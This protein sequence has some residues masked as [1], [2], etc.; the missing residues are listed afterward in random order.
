MLEGRSVVALVPMRHHSERVPGKNFRPLAGKPL[1]AYILETLSACKSLDGIVVDT[2][3]ETIHQGVR[4]RFPHVQLIERPEHLRAGHIPMNDVLAYD[5]RQVEADFYLQ[6]HSTNPLLRVET[7][8]RA[9]QT[10]V[11]CYPDHDSLFSVTRLQ[12]RLW[13]AEGEPINHDPGVLLRT[14]DLPPIY[15]ENSCLYIFER[16]GFLARGNRLGARPLLF[17]IDAEEAWDID[18]EL[19]FRVVE[20]LMRARRAGESRHG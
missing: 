9:L 18:E 1:Y 12:T 5:L 17:E 16:Q 10:F 20:C 13:S 15:E 2:D 8:N 19:D 7:V 11:R 14:Q 4:E 3:S 6:T